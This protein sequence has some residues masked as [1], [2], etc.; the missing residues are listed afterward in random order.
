MGAA[1]TR[2]STRAGGCFLSIFILAGFVLGLAIKNPMK[3]ILIGTGLGILLALAT[4][5]IDRRRR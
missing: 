4:W 1:M 3:G 2:Q 5:L